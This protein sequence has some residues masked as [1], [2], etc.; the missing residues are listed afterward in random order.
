MM[1]STIEIN[2]AK[3]FKNMLSMIIARGKNPV[4]MIRSDMLLSFSMSEIF[5]KT[6][7]DEI[8]KRHLE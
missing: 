3:H 2:S 4:P 8:R 5:Q 7:I 6:V 1:L